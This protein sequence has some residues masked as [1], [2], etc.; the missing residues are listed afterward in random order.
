MAQ[1]G[2]DA[3]PCVTTAMRTPPLGRAGAWAPSPGAW[4]GGTTTV[5]SRTTVVPPQP[6]SSATRTASD[7][8]G[9]GAPHD[10]A[11]EGILASSR[12]A[13]AGR[14]VDR[15][16]AVDDREAI[17]Q[18]AQ[19]AAGVE[20]GASD[21]VVGDEHDDPVAVAAQ[22]HARLGGLRVARRRC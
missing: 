5:G 20:V 15:E 12:R 2:L 18:A 8:R 3:C 17:L 10:V 4:P 9:G 14:A 21:A 22:L 11:G 19:S 16:G 6:A 13:A 1:N 7:G